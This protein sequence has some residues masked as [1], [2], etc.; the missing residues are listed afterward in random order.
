MVFKN[1]TPYKVIYKDQF[2]RK[3]WPRSRQKV[4]NDESRWIHMEARTINC[5]LN[6]IHGWVK[7]EDKAAE[8]EKYN[9][10]EVP[11]RKE[12]TGELLNLIKET[13]TPIPITGGFLVSG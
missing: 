4:V 11:I 9:N 2:R 12:G 1:L 8:K 3:E 6:R 7:R 5:Q 10:G 13:D